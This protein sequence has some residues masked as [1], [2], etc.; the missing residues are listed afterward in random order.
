MRQHEADDHQ[1]DGKA[2]RCSTDE[3]A[4]RLGSMLWRLV[5]SGWHGAGRGMVMGCGRPEGGGMSGVASSVVTGRDHEVVHADQPERE[6]R[7]HE[8]AGREFAGRAHPSIVTRLS[9]Q[10]APSPL[11][12]L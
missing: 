8:E 1:Q 12:R 11:S 2:G 4:W 5:S 3:P 6:H 7:H 9:G 10:R